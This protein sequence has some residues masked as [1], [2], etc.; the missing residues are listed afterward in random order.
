MFPLDT[1]TKARYFPSNSQ[2]ISSNL[3]TVVRL[4]VTEFLLEN[5]ERCLY[6]GVGLETTGRLDVEV[7]LLRDT[8]GVEVSLVLVFIQLRVLTLGPLVRYGVGGVTETVVGV[9]L[10][11][12]T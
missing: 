5:S 8:V 7:E 3:M 1:S 9:V 10:E 11:T 12:N 6:N 2:V 4:Q